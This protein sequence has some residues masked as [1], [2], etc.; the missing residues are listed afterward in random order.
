MVDRNEALDERPRF[1]V[2]CMNLYIRQHNSCV[3][4]I[5][6]VLPQRLTLLQDRPFVRRH[7]QNFERRN[8]EAVCVLGASRQAAEMHTVVERHLPVSNLQ[9]GQ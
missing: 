9:L 8:D 1:G 4:D 6:V 7:R 2:R 3:D 5:G